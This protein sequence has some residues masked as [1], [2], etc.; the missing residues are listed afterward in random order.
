MDKNCTIK[1]ICICCIFNFT[2][3]IF[4][5]FSQLESLQFISQSLSQKVKLKSEVYHRE[6]ERNLTFG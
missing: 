5:Y 2:T 6:R 4:N 1:L 3:V